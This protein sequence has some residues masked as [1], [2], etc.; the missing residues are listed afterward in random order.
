MT[1]FPWL[2]RLVPT[3]HALNSLLSDRRLVLLEDA[4][5]SQLDNILGNAD[6]IAEIPTMRPSSV[7]TDGH[8]YV[9]S[10]E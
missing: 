6:I 7:S 10:V 2:V 4:V 9:A 5:K 3:F 8:T 1:K